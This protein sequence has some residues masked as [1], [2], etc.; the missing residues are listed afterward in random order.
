MYENLFVLAVFVFAYSVVSVRVERFWLS[1]P[2]VFTAFGMAMGPRGAGLLTIEV[3]GEELRT[4]AE[5]TLAVVLFTDA[6]GANLHVLERSKQIPLRLLFLGLP[7]TI[8][9]GFLAGGLVLPGLTMLE[10]AILATMLAPTDAA[11]GSAVVTNPKVPAAMREGLN[12]ES[13]LNDGICVPVL[14][15]FL[16]LADATTS[17]GGSTT[18]ALRLVLQQIGIGLVVG[19]ALTALGAHAIRLCA[20]RGWISDPWRQIIVVALAFACFALAQSFGGSGFIASFSGGLLFGAMTKKHKAELI[21]TAEGIGKTLALATWV[22]F[23]SAVVGPA[24][25]LLRW[26]IVVYALLSLTVVRM[27]PVFLSLLG[28]GVPTA[29][30][31]FA[32]WFGP[33]GLASIVFIVLVLGKR[34]PGQETLALAVTC[35]ICLSILAHGISANPLIAALARTTARRDDSGAE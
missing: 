3:G 34:L 25:A 33:R 10:A 16:A 4:L 5:L 24:L 12:V 13:G 20:A 22:L 18:L 11:L 9:L 1:G 27:L 32:G 2:I 17:A 6:A 35:T 23:G 8:L 26:P 31:L 30:K 28:S 19:L 15:L 14:L 21:D 7:L 29:G